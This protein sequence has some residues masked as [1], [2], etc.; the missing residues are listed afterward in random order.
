MYERTNYLAVGIFVL[1]GTIVLFAVGFWV[2]DVGQTVPTTR[3]TVVFDRD[4]NGLSE[5]G[6]VRY[7]G[8][9]VGEVTTIELS[10]S[11]D[12]AIEG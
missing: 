11:G 7:M 6:P 9:D 12:T 2:G 1:V 8:V 3:Y 4:V 10:R 5:G